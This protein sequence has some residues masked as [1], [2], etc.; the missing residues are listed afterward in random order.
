MRDDFDSGH[1]AESTPDW[2]RQEMRQA[3]ESVNVLVVEDDSDIRDLLVTLLELAGYQATAFGT[4]EQALEELRQRTFDLVLTDYAL[5]NHTGGW[6]LQQAA[7]EG[8]LDATP[9]IVVTAH[10]SPGEV[11]GYEV[12]QKPFDLDD[13]V[14]RVR[15]R[16]EGGTPRR[17]RT[18]ER[19]GSDRSGGDGKDGCPQPIELILYV[20]AHSPRTATA[21]ENI[22]Q[23]LARY[24]SDRVTL[25]I[26]DVQK[27]PALGERDDVAF[28]PTLERRSP[29]PRTFIL[30]HMS[31]PEILIELLADCEP[32]Y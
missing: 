25:T 21:I 31:N 26:C 14:E 17:P 1:E 16:L 20:S 32:E 5:P 7:A 28:T 18:P 9:V 27:D 19:P 22:K 23:V 8:L 3:F 10:P 11:A 6:L 15:R 24:G 12:V 30:G 4:A 13:L 2:L 29:G